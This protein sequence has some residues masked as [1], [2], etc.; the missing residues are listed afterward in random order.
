MTTHRPA[1]LQDPALG[2]PPRCA[3]AAEGQRRGRAHKRMFFGVT[4]LPKVQYSEAR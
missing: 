4:H 2:A 1:S 3:V